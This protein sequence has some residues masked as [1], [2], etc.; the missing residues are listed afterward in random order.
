MRPLFSNVFGAP[1]SNPAR[2][3][4][5]RGC[6]R[7]DLYGLATGGLSS[8]VLTSFS[9]VIVVVP[10][11]VVI[12]VSC[13]VDDLLC[14]LHPTIPI[15]ATLAIRVAAMMRFIFNTFH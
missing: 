2:V 1:R 6:T 15:E 8:V 10:R 4:P 14:S 9:V 12:V 7:L 3:C 5:A 11:G 13:L